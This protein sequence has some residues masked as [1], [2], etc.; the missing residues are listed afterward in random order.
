MQAELGEDL[1][2]GRKV[3]SDDT[4]M[5]KPPRALCRTDFLKVVKKQSSHPE[6]GMVLGCVL[7]TGENAD[8]GI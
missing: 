1:E 5:R 8:L 6:G 7:T 3:G 4:G 2:S